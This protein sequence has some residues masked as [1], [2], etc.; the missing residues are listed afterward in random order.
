[1]LHENVCIF[2]VFIFVVFA[3]VTWNEIQT[4]SRFV[5]DVFIDILCCQWRE[6]S[7]SDS[8]GDVIR[9]YTV[10][11]VAVQ[12]VDNW[13]QTPYIAPS[14]GN[15]LYVDVTFSMRKCT[16]Y[17]NPGRLQQCKVGRL[18]L[19]SVCAET[20]VGLSSMHCILHTSA[21][22]Q[23]SSISASVSGI[24]AH[25]PRGVDLHN[26][27]SVSLTMITTT[28]I[29]WNRP[30]GDV[31]K[32]SSLVKSSV[33]KCSRSERVLRWRLTF[34]TEIDCPTKSPNYSRLQH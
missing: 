20:T 34:A 21:V 28:E 10:C 31:T 24:E 18:N 30:A 26:W 5:L 13:L 23:G 3:F 27:S 2:I 16:K 32:T 25:E 22:S 6:A 33:V 14:P 19:I 7:Y 11:N 17:P 8:N 15:R 12:S 29:D 9:V 1:M 4:Q